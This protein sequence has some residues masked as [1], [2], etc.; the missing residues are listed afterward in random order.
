MNKFLHLNSRK[1]IH[2]HFFIPEYQFQKV[3]LCFLVETPSCGGP[4]QR[5][6]CPPALRRSLVYRPTVAAILVATTSNV[7]LLLG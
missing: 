4:G 1:Y 5:R 2:I 7:L 3:F 6:V